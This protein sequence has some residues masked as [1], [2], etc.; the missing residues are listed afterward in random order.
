MGSENKVVNGA[1]QSTIVQ[2]LCWIQKMPTRTVQQE[3]KERKFTETALHLFL[4]EEFS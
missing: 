4:L 3:S 2:G 1:T